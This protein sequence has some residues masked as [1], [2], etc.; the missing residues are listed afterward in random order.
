MFKDEPGEGSGVTRSFYTAIA[1]VSL[2][3]WF[4]VVL[5][6]IE[7]NLYNILKICLVSVKNRDFSA[8]FQWFEHNSL[9][10]VTYYSN[11]RYGIKKGIKVN[12]CEVTTTRW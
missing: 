4:T 3:A 2:Y 10:G 6:C 5:Y 7:L 11:S 9:W 1:E 8:L 12:F